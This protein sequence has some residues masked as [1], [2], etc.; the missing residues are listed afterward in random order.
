MFQINEVLKFEQE[1]FR[2]LSQFGDQFVWISIDNKSD[3]PSIIDWASLENAMQNG[4]LHRV[5]DPYA[6]LV[7]EIPEHGSTAQVKRD[8]NYELISPIIKLDDYYDPKQRAKAIT[9]IMSQHKT[10][11]QT[12]YRLIRQYWQ[13]GQTVNALLPD[14]KN[15]GAYSG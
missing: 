15:S 14:Y 7:L 4:T 10:T 6:S 3:F 13:R 1:R 12:L 11:K 9:K 2:I 5:N 8:R